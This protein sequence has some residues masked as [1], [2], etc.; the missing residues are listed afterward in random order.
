MGAKNCPTPIGQPCVVWRNKLQG[1][2]RKV[3]KCWQNGGGGGGGNGPKTI[4]PPVTRVDLIYICFPEYVSLHR[5]QQGPRLLTKISFSSIRHRTCISNYINR[6]CN[7]SSNYLSN[8]NG[9][10][11]KLPLNVGHG[12]IITPEVW[13]RFHVSRSVQP[14]L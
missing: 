4:S 1:F 14:V 11:V 5:R 13:L 6:G 12:W 8:C 10:L 9:S 2:S 7:Y 3:Q